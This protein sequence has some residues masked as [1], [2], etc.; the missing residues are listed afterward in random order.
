[1]TLY[2]A[3]VS[4]LESTKVKATNRNI[5]PYSSFCLL[6]RSTLS[7]WNLFFSIATNFKSAVLRFFMENQQTGSQYLLLSLSDPWNSSSIVS[8]SKGNAGSKYTQSAARMT[9]GRLYFSGTVSGNG[10]PQGNET[11]MTDEERLF[12]SMFCFWS[13]RS[14]GRS[15]MRIGGSDL[16]DTVFDGRE[17]A[18]ARASLGAVSMGHSAIAKNTT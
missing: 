18:R 2:L 13:G 17:R 12:R 5:L 15:V 1:M 11:E 8:K 7:T 3:C 14:C 4:S 6:C 16:M 9:S 10:D